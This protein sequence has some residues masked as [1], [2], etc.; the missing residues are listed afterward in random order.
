MRHT[1]KVET[2]EVNTINLDES[3]LYLAIIDY[4]KKVKGIDIDVDDIEIDT[5]SEVIKVEVRT[6]NTVTNVLKPHQIDGM[7]VTCACC[8]RSVQ[9]PP[10]NIREGNGEDRLIS[11]LYPNTVFMPDHLRKNANPGDELCVG[12]KTVQTIPA[13]N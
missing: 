6:E 3:D 7:M 9:V 11:P 1:K 2:T 10:E 5:D 8:N 13:L 4:I 12:S